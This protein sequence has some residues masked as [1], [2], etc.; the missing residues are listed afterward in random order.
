MQSEQRAVK[1]LAIPAEHPYTQAVR[2]AGVE[3]LPDPDIDGNWWPHP[4]LTARYWEQLDPA[5]RPD[6]MHVH[7]GFEHFSPAEIR[8]LVEALPVPLVVTVH[9]IDNPHLSDQREH[10]E[11]LQILVDAAAAVLT[12]TE[13]AAEVLRHRFGVAEPVVVPHP[14]IALPI[15]APK[16]GRAA[17]FLKSLRG[18]VVADPQFY[19]DAAAGVPLDVYVH[20][21]EATRALREALQG[22]DLRL[23]VHEPMGDPELHAAVASAGVCIL[24]YTRGTHSGWLEMCRDQ[25]T[26]VAVPDVG[27]YAGQADTPA[28]VAEYRAGNGESAG[29][30]A[31]ALLAGGEVPL[32]VDR[33]AQLE[34]VCEVHRAIYAGLALEGGRGRR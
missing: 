26:S 15:D 13:C 34:R 22:A 30:A 29:E 7:F 5:D 1:I 18:N 3:Y 14:R 32:A 33:A 19:L 2:P 6:A 31:A 8:E 9:D 20:D 27:C 16:S 25:A 28:A 23:R 24:P 11:R 10:H 4:A 12:L 21:V 17:V